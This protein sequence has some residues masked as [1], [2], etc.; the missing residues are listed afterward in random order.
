MKRKRYVEIIRVFATILVIIGHCTFYTI[1]TAIP[2]MGCDYSTTI[3]DNSVTWQIANQIVQFIYI[4]HMP[5]FFALSGMVYA[6]CIQQGKYT[7]YRRTINNKFRNLVLP[8]FAIT[9]IYNIPIYWWAG[10]FDNDFGN[11]IL[12][13][14]G[15]GENHLWFLIALFYCF[16][17]THYI[18]IYH[19]KYEIEIFITGGILL[20]LISKKMPYQLQCL[21]ID[22]LLRYYIW[23]IS[24]YLIYYVKEHYLKERLFCFKFRNKDIKIRT[25]ILKLVLILSIIMVTIGWYKNVVPLGGTILSLLIILLIFAVSIDMNSARAERISSRTWVKVI[26]KYSKH[27]FYYGVPMNYIIF[28]I[29]IR[30][31][32]PIVFSNFD[33]F[34]FISLRFLTQVFFPIIICTCVEYIRGHLKRRKDIQ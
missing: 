1:S 28:G 34:L 19:S 33:S 31:S 20:W 29:V 30:R 16:L 14:I 18:H 17:F 15:F 3:I 8:Y 13:F 2:S 12:Y 10:Y 11:V 25:S 23:F 32:K 21:Y 4:F 7:N 26:N 9:T 24:G 22:R 5:L 27:I 6:I